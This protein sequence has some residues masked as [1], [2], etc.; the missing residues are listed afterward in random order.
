MGPEC[1][2]ATVR[3]RGSLAR[4]SGRTDDD[5]LRALDALEA[6]SNARREELKR[7]AAQL[8]AAMSR[9]QVLRSLASDLRHAPRKGEI[10]RRG[11]L[12]LARAPRAAW[13]RATGR[14]H[15]A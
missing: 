12:K 7:I 2:E 9:R 13:R 10:V 14:R 3:G 5:V 6:E 8:P 11:L 4:V 15:E 1:T